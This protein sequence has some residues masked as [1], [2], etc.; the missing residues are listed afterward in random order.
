MKVDEDEEFKDVAKELVMVFM[1][2]PSLTDHS[3]STSFQ[4][5]STLLNDYMPMH[6][7]FKETNRIS[8]AL[9]SYHLCICFSYLLQCIHGPNCLITKL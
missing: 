6:R 2:C 1:S 9:L 8:T 7:H 4:L 3:A 5:C